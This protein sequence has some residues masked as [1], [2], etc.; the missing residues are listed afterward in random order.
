MLEPAHQV[1]TDDVRVEGL[2]LFEMIDAEGHL[3]QRSHYCRHHLPASL[4]RR[5]RSPSPGRRHDSGSRRFQRSRAHGEPHRN[6][7]APAP[8]YLRKVAQGGL[9]HPPWRC[10]R[11]SGIRFDSQAVV[12]GHPELL[13]ASEV[14]LRRLDGDMAQEEL[15]LVKFA[16]RQMAQTGTGASQIVQSELVDAG[17]GH[18]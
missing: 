6:H 2:H 12:H 15:D 7:I 9:N 11:S 10:A 1:E 16:T 3:A 13:L 5:H 8:D 14:A 18:G 4:R 17:A